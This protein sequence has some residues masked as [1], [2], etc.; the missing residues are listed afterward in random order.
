MSMAG[1]MTN[2]AT[3]TSHRDNPGRSFGSARLPSPTPRALPMSSRLINNI[4]RLT[5]TTTDWL[6]AFSRW[7]WAREHGARLNARRHRHTVAAV[8]KIGYSRCLMTH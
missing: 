6:L 8:R 3:P 5:I 1:L 4:C 7:W 2:R